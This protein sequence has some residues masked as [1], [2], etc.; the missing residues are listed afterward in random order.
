MIKLTTIMAAGLFAVSTAFAGEHGDAAS[1]APKEEMGFKM[2]C[3]IPNAPL[4]LTD[5]QQKKW[6]A[7][8]Q[9]HHKTGC[10][11]ASESKLMTQAKEILTPEQ[12]AQFKEKYE[13]GPKMKM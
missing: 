6:T 5:A 2:A 3:T 11:E 13:N 7:A 12:F 9:E 10:T 8:M 4:H 1:K